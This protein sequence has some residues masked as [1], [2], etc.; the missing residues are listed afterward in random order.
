MNKYFCSQEFQIYD[1]GSNTTEFLLENL[2]PY[3]EYN[4]SIRCRSAFLENDNMWSGFNSTV[5]KTHADGKYVT[6]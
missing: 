2:I 5:F 4:V 3:M 1:V 6:V